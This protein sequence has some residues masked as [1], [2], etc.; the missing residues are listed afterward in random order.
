MA[1]QA[2]C[3][4]ADAKAQK[5]PRPKEK[6]SWE[7][8]ADANS[9]QHQH[10]PPPTPSYVLRLASHPKPVKP[11]KW[12][13]SHIDGQLK[14]KERRSPGGHK[15]ILWG[16]QRPQSSAATFTFG[17][18]MIAVTRFSSTPFPS[19]PRAIAPSAVERFRALPSV[20]GH[21]PG[22]WAVP[23]LQRTRSSKT[24]PTSGAP[25][26]LISRRWRLGSSNSW[27]R[28]RCLALRR[29]ACRS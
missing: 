7:S 19:P 13:E 5:S 17:K 27:V 20:V 25:G 1:P 18:R 4:F 6:E 10:R 14:A 21:R 22:K 8:L 24:T 26:S 12:P 28:C 9:T 15:L 29:L 11:H 2:A 16:A 23:T 3:Q